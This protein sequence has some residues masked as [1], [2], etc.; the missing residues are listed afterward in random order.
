[1][2]KA[3]V[4]VVSADHVLHRLIRRSLRNY[5][6]E[7]ICVDSDSSI[8]KELLHLNPDVLLLDNPSGCQQICQHN[9]HMSIIVLS[10][11]TDQ[12]HIAQVLDQGAD[13][14]VVQPFGAEEL[15][16]RI[17]SHLRRANMGP[18]KSAP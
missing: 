12:K 5:D 15:A 6:Y 7:V 4:L 18:H 3:K 1:L 14:Y 13:D 10:S 8:M 11:M 16:A 2:K 9:M 17:R